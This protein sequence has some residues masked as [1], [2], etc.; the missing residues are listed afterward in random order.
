VT[1][2]LL[3]AAGLVLFDPVAADE[4]KALHSSIRNSEGLAFMMPLVGGRLIM[5]I[6][7]F[8]TDEKEITDLPRQIGTLEELRVAPS[9]IWPRISATILEPRS[10]KILQRRRL[11]LRELYLGREALIR[12]LM[13]EANAGETA[14]RMEELQNELGLVARTLPAGFIRQQVP[15]ENRKI[16]SP[17][18]VSD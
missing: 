9:L 1:S 17:D 6:A 10:T 5:P 8:V 15:V 2:R 11:A 3:E 7:A 14:R 18:D 4:W 12:R 16:I 13:E